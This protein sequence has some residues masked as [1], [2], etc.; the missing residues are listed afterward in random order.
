M[1]VTVTA[2]HVRTG[3]QRSTCKCPVA[4]AISDA[5]DERLFVA[6]SGTVAIVGEWIYELP[7]VA[8]CFIRNFDDSCSAHDLS[9]ANVARVFKP[10]TFEL[11]EKL[12]HSYLP[13]PYYDSSRVN[14]A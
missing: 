1:R 14:K 5:Q 8:L 9:W 6:V 4:L 11:G 3:E 2:T 7:L 13:N 12:Y 10:F